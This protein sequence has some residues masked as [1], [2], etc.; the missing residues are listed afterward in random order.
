[1][2][3][4]KILMGHRYDEL[5]AQTVMDEKVSKILGNS[6][7]V[8]LVSVIVSGHIIAYQRKQIEEL[9]N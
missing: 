4:H 2:N 3:L 6:L 7:I 8:L 5:P 1:M 9:K